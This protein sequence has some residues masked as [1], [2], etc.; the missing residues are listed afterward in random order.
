[1]VV[2]SINGMV[3]RSINGMVVRSINGMGLVYY[4]EVTIC[5]LVIRVAYVGYAHIYILL[6]EATICYLVSK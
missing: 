4:Y 1:M 6:Y 5:Y 3:V 2:R